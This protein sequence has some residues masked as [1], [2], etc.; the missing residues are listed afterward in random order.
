MDTIKYLKN[1]VKTALSLNKTLVGLEDVLTH[2]ERGEY[3]LDIG[4]K[5]E[6]E[7]FYTDVIYRTN[8]AYEG[9]LKEAYSVLK[10]DD[11]GSRSPN[12]I[13]TYLLNNNILNERVI[14][15]L[16]NY[17][18][19]WRNTSTH[20]YHLFFNSGEAFSAILSV[21]SFIHILLNQ[22]IDK[23]FY[24]SEKERIAPLI[25]KIKKTFNE[26]YNE[27]D[28]VG[29]VGI[30][31]KSYENNSHKIV[32]DVRNFRSIERE[33]I[34]GILAHINYLDPTLD[35]ELEPT[36]E[37]NKSLRPDMIISN[38]NGEKVLIELKLLNGI[39]SNSQYRNFENQLLSY[40]TYS[41]IKNG[42]LFLINLDKQLILD[43]VTKT[44]EVGKE[45]I[46]I[47]SIYGKLNLE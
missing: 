43:D 39:V 28:F 11:D 36:I 13:E 2:I 7:R 23:L 38:K 25:D 30:L 16:E 5:D 35:V 4:N 10:K 18:R 24:L 45:K 44:F 3:M 6:D 34:N 37:S 47:H 31:L 20:D 46:I 40:L 15:L 26:D 12:N 21:T 29:K 27:L 14:K 17:R 22:I 33:F 41:N 19:E 1:Q 42:I 8:H 9:I 32:S